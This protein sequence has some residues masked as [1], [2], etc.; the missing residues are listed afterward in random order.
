M[1]N[2][3]TRDDKG[4]VIAPDGLPAGGLARIREV[5]ATT[6][7]GRSKLYHMI[8]VGELPVRRFGRSVRVAW[9]DVRR[10]FLGGV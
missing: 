10:V 4:R 3:L 7:L 2:T 5:E 1:N 8:E 6:G 9:A